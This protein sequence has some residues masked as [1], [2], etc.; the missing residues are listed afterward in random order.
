M[1]W[2]VERGDLTAALRLVTAVPLGLVNERRALIDDLLTRGRE[3][4]PANVV[5]QAQLTLSDLALEQGDWAAAVVA[6]S[7]A[8]TGFDQVGDLLHSAW[9]RLGGVTASWGAGDRVAAERLL[10]ECLDAFRAL[11]DDFGLAMTLWAASL[12]DPDRETA[13]AMAVEAERRFREFGAPMMRAHALEGRAL[14]EL[15]ADDLDTA[16]QFLREAVA[17]LAGAGNLGCTAH[18]LE[19]VAVWASARGEEETAGEIVGAADT[20]RKTSGAGHK[21]WEVRARQGG[22][23]DANVLG[24]TAAVREAI[25]RGRRHSLA[26][27]AALVDVLL[28]PPYGREN[29][30]V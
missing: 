12:L 30:S 19:S 6:S 25:A 4:H 9:A 8:R 15:E 18:A 17:I 20:L 11:D 21:P 26:S 1:E 5:A 7:A 23:Y 2:A 16:P 10:A 13:T 29:G 14:I 27:A 24:D 22:N 3:L 28:T